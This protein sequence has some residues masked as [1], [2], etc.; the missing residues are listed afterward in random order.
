MPTETF[1]SLRLLKK[2][3]SRLRI[4]EVGS[5]T[6]VCTQTQGHSST[7]YI[8]YGF[9]DKLA[10]KKVYQDQQNANKNL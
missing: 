8:I 3:K 7:S 6:G 9:F 5:M 1:K 2:T 4:S 10:G